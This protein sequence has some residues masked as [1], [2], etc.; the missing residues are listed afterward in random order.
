MQIA[1]AVRGGSISAEDVVRDHLEQID[2]RAELNAFVTV[3]GDRALAEARHRQAAGGLDGPL[4]GVPLAPKDL[5]DT[6][7]L[8]TTYGSKH[9]KKHVPGRTAT[10]VQRLVDAGAIVVGKANLHEYAWG[11][12]SQ[13]PFHGRV[14][15]PRHPGRIP[16][17]SSGGSAVAVAAGMA[18]VSL[19]TDTGGSIRIPSAA[20]GTS[21][22]KARWGT[23]P[24]DGCFPLVPQMDH[25]G[26]M[27]RSMAECALLLNV[28]ADVEP[29]T[30]RLQGLRVGLLHPIDDGERLED[31][32]AHVEEAALPPCD[33]VLRWFSAVAAAT[34]RDRLRSDPE[35]YSDDLRRKLEGGMRVAAADFVIDGESIERWRRRCAEELPYDVLVCP[36]IPC[37]L[38]SADEDETPELRL[39]V[40]RYTRPFNALGWPSATTRDGTMFSGQSEERVLGAAL[41]WEE[42]LPPVLLA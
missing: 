38:P 41:A 32:G 29:P 19:G 27:A 16:G 24:T 17:G 15:N 35:D 20:C 39:R 42:G 18:A 10:S 36:T 9:F 13:N 30:P 1:F 7:G 22:Y 2:A 31:A 26:P 25:V 34:H 12:T 23:V 6:A 5:L 28:L 37:E 4:A 21:G 40:T 33:E 11:I 14:R 8:R 3:D